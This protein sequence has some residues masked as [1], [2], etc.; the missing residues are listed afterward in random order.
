MRALLGTTLALALAGCATDSPSPEEPASAVVPTAAA[1]GAAAGSGLFFTHVSPAGRSGFS[2]GVATDAVA[3]CW[4]QG[5]FG[6]LGDGSDTAVTRLSPFPVAGG[7]RFLDIRSNGYSCGLTTDHLAWCW[8]ANTRGNLGDGTTTT[9]SIPVRVSGTRKWRQID[10]GNDGH[11]CAVTLGNV[12]FCWGN[13]AFGQVGDK[14]KTERHVPVHVGGSLRFTE[15]SAGMLF[16]CAVSTDQRIFCWGLNRD[17]NLGDGT[18][19]DHLGPYLVAGAQRYVHVSADAGI[20]GTHHACAVSTTER[21][22]C[23]G[24]HDAGQL[25][26]GT[27]TS[28]LAPHAV[29]GA[30]RFTGVSAGEF[31]SCAVTTERRGYC[32][33]DGSNG[34]LGTGLVQQSHTPV[35]V[36]GGRQFLEIRTDEDH[37]CGV[38]L[39]NRG[40]CWGSNFSGQLGDGTTDTHLVPTVVGG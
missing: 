17:G 28:R 9:S 39:N 38:A 32:W 6:E 23:W 25:G 35:A 19:R 14:T 31:Y 4:G 5:L 11:T 12:L 7:H 15:V 29:P 2:C 10:V 22:F 40:L 16:T 34:Q 1:A 24:A 20:P 13:N 27:T 26:D 3:Y 36:A 8:G 30:L 37:T 18:L 21:I 33:G